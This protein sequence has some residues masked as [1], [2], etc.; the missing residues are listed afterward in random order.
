M[1]EQ[2]SGTVTLVFTDI[3]GSTRLLHELGQ[4]A[5]QEALA[6]H[7][8]I[9]REA[10][11]RHSGYEVDYEGDSF[12]YAFQSAVEAVAAVEE[13]LR[14]LERGPIRIRVGVHTGEPGL[15]PPK[16]VGMDVHLTAR[17]MA[18]GH[19]G[20]VLLTPAT[21]ELV[22]LKLKEL[23][24]QR[25]RDIIEPVY[26]YQLGDREFPPLRSQSPSNLPIP[27]TALI[28]R[29]RELGELLTLLRRED[30]RLLTLTGPGGTGKTRVALELGRRLE[31]GHERR[32]LFVDLSGATDE[33][34]PLESLAVALGVREQAQVELLEAVSIALAAKDLLL[35]LDNC[36]QVA[37]PVAQLVETLLERTRTLRLVLTSRE[38]LHVAGEHCLRLAPL[39]VP[40][41]D[42]PMPGST[43]AVR[44]FLDRVRAAVPSFTTDAATLAVAAELVRG[45][46]GLPLAIELAAARAA[47]LGVAEV[48]DRLDERFRILKATGRHATDRHRSLEAALDW[49]YQLLDADGQSAFRRLSVFP[50]SFS[51]AAA[52]VII[53]PEAL[54]LVPALA[55]A[56]LLSIEDVGRGVYRYRLLETLRTYANVKLVEA[57]EKDETNQQLIVWALAEAESA[58]ATLDTLDERRGLATFDREGDNYCVALAWALA[59][60]ETAALRLA[61]AISGW[62]TRRG[63]YSE[64]VAALNAALA[65]SPGATAAMRAR[66]LL[67]L[68]TSISVVGD[69][70]A[71]AAREAAALFAELAEPRNTVKSLVQLAACERNQ[72]HLEEAA[73]V[74]GEALEIAR[75]ANDPSGI[76][77]SLVG[78]GFASLYAG[79]FGRAHSWANEALQI[80]A[81]DIGPEAQ[82]RREQLLSAAAMLLGELGEAEAACESGLAR[83]TDDQVSHWF[84]GIL[85]WLRWQQG[86]GLE[87]VELARESLEFALSVGD[88]IGIANALDTYLEIAKSLGS[89]EMAAMLYGAIEQANPYYWTTPMTA[90]SSGPALALAEAA[91]GPRAKEEAVARGRA[92]EVGEI[93]VLVRDLESQLR[94][95]GGEP[96]GSGAAVDRG[97]PDA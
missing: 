31:Q 25:L 71:R 40:G 82:T 41:R 29:E 67:E 50:T 86:K 70:A 49:S 78:L 81:G 55:D 2:P 74:A 54:E 63:R 66:T 36:E 88:R 64:N 65:I 52:E 33:L 53:G 62:R 94:S 4:D 12:F 73:R 76:V 91:L 84:R 57:G 68:S 42:D 60:E 89:A 38:P 21:R 27:A 3:E 1:V 30:F 26:L 32:V 35:I 8:L 39:P 14:E 83:A 44:L 19:G 58:T 61:L 47:L 46:D 11:A 72:G 80:P 95:G 28:G 18:A 51:L 9:V 85:A 92:M 37:V 56:S 16:Y 87:A 13:A 96:K 20:Q 93:L 79:D 77:N 90:A 34:G 7:R 97:G 15:D 59:A 45:L 43:A 10:C 23:G 69:G 48:R 75:G 17:V 6:E 22:D 24:E 5:Y